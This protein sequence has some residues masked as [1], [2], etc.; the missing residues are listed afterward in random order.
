MV[1]NH[2]KI[3]LHLLNDLSLISPASYHDGL[4]VAQ[5]CMLEIVLFLVNNSKQNKPRDRMVTD[6]VV[7]REIMEDL[8]LHCYF[9]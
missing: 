3:Y 6:D 8:V 7:V 9:S 4:C 2:Y 1:S 5:N